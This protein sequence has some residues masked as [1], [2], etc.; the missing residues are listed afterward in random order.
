MGEIV[1]LGSGGISLTE[2]ISR[3]KGAKVTGIYAITKEK[4]MLINSELGE[5]AANHILPAGRHEL[6]RVPDPFGHSRNWLV[7]KGTRIGMPE[8]SWTRWINGVLGNIE[9]SENF[10]EPI[11]WGP[12]EIILEE[13]G[14][15][16]PPPPF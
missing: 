14:V 2:A 5:N 11:D 8:G 15:I 4:R 10:G 12:M 6:E 3:T 9:S 1:V 7:L 13:D 16:V